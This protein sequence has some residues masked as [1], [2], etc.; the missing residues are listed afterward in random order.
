MDPRGDGGCICLFMS[1]YSLYMG[2]SI[3]NQQRMESWSPANKDSSLPQM[4]SSISRRSKW[5]LTFVFFVQ[6]PSNSPLGVSDT[7]KL[8]EGCWKCSV[9][10]RKFNISHIFHT[11]INNAKLVNSECGVVWTFQLQNNKRISK[12]MDAPRKIEIRLIGICVHPEKFKLG[13]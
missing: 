8:D 7:F 2:Y 1:S 13:Q 6:E 9:F 3:L 11:S 12:M 10:D 5:Q 4:N